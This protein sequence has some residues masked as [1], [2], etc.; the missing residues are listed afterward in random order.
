MPENRWEKI[1]TAFLFSSHLENTQQKTQDGNCFEDS[2]NLG[3]QKSIVL[4]NLKAAICPKTAVCIELELRF[5]GCL[6]K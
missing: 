5:R 3:V 1:V 4:Q 2:F 6:A